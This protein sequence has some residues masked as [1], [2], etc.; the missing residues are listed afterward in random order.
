M[1][2][3]GPISEKEKQE[4]QAL[5]PIQKVHEASKKASKFGLILI[6]LSV[7]FIVILAMILKR[8]MF[9]DKDLNA[10]KKQAEIELGAE[11]VVFENNEL[12]FNFQNNVLFEFDKSSLTI[13]SMRKLS[14]IAAS[15]NESMIVEVIGHADSVGSICHNYQLSKERARTVYN[16]IVTVSQPDK[17][18]F[19]GL[20]EDYPITSNRTK[21]GRSYNRRVEIRIRTKDEIPSGFF[22]GLAHRVSTYIKYNE[23]AIIIPFFASILT[24]LTTI[25]SLITWII[26]RMN[27]K[28]ETKS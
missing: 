23:N 1:K 14:S 22:N 5:P 13:K 2:A 17:I 18:K 26:K 16:F 3:I 19:Y 20:G 10:V 8:D 9:I 27:M 21:E 6:S 4:F 25:I 28:K 15:I 24:I 12:S 11:Q 7:V